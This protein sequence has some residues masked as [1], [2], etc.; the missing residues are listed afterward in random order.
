M[1]HIRFRFSILNML[2]LMTIIALAI[3]VVLLWRKVG[4][5]RAEVRRLRDEVGVLAVDDE[6]KIHIIRVNTRDELTWKWRVWVPQGKA[7][8]VRCTD[9]I[10][11]KA[12]SVNGSSIATSSGTI[13][14]RDPGE[15]VVEFRIDKDRRTDRWNGALYAN[16]ARVGNYEQLWVN[17][18][19]TNITSSGIG[20]QTQ[21]FDFSKPIELIRLVVTESAIAGKP[22]PTT[23]PSGFV[24][25]IEPAT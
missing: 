2:M 3:S 22:K 20:T 19:G 24:I 12:G 18:P 15:N 1:S 14:L 7:L 17:W 5:L 16:T 8:E 21:S 11:S 10:G 23:A 9:D 6:S 25:S 13:W 4:P